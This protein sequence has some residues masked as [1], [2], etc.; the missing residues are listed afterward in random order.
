MGVHL[1]SWETQATSSLSGK[2]V[3][4]NMMVRYELSCCFCRKPHYVVADERKVELWL[5]GMLIQNA[6]PE[7]TATE[8][9]QL[10]SRMCPSCQA[11]FFDN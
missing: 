2:E 1:R 9:E 5:N 4:L 3:Q 6:L 10:I 11:E 8:R 7:L